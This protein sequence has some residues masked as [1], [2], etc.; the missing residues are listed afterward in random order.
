[1]CFFPRNW[2]GNQANTGASLRPSFEKP[3]SR[4]LQ[5]NGPCDVADTAGGLVKVGKDRRK[6]MDIFGYCCRLGRRQILPSLSDSLNRKGGVPVGCSIMPHLC[7]S[8]LPTPGAAPGRRRNSRLFPRSAIWIVGV[9]T[10][11]TQSSI[12]IRGCESKGI[13]S[14]RARGSQCRRGDTP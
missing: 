12:V 7:S 2:P 14:E 4:H 1:M 9:L 8:C 13:A 10:Y 6:F 3:P 5:L 11:R